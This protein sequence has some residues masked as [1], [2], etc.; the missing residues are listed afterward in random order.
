MGDVFS[1]E[2]CNF[3]VSDQEPRFRRRIESPINKEATMFI[4]PWEKAAECEQA[5]LKASDSTRR[6]ILLNLREL[7][8]S[9]AREGHRHTPQW[10]Q[11]AEKL[12]RLQADLTRPWH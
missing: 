4:D 11:E 7:W 5:L 9:L 12:G 10:E 1:V 2:P 8:V 6:G 3:F